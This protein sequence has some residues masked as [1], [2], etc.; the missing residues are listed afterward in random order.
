MLEHHRSL[1]PASLLSF[2][3]SLCF[4]VP[5]FMAINFP[6]RDNFHYRW[7]FPKIHSN[8]DL[9]FHHVF[10]RFASTSLFVLFKF[11]FFVMLYSDIRLWLL[12]LLGASTERKKVMGNNVKNGYTSK[13]LGPCRDPLSVKG[14]T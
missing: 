2:F 6:F 5:G 11:C 13:F 8:G 1:L 14:P 4:Y 7:Q 9:V 3:L 10:G 12:P